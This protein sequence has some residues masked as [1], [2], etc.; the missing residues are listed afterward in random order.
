MSDD[1]ASAIS[2]LE[3]KVQR[4]RRIRNWNAVTACLWTVAT[5]IMWNSFSFARGQ[6]FMLAGGIAFTGVTFMYWMF[7]YGAY[8]NYSAAV[9]K[10]ARYTT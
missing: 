4:A 6:H 3:T 9:A 1:T 10:L 7:A 8:R 2:V 5:L